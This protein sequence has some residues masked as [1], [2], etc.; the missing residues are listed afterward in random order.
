L[1]KIAMTNAVVW[2]L[3]ETSEIWAAADSRVTTGVNE[4]VR[5]VTD[6]AIKVL[7]LNVDVHGETRYSQAGGVPQF[8][9]ER[10]QVHLSRFGR[11]SVLVDVPD[12]REGQVHRH[13]LSAKV[14]HS[15]AMDH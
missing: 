3:S 12:G 1:G 6:Q 7:S 2:K 10:S 11:V 14:C 5:R 15:L 9:A 4:R 8:A 13:A